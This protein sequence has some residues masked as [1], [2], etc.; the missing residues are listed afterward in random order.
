MREVPYLRVANVQRGFLDLAEMKTILAEEEEIDALRLREGDILFTEGGDRDKLGRGWVWN[1]EVAE[2]I[3]QNHIFR[4]RLYLP[5]LEPRFISYHG[6]HFGQKWFVR[7]GKQTTNLASINK[8]VLSRFPVPVAPAQEQRRIVA[9]IDEL[10]SDLD[11][12]VAALERVTANLKRYRAAVLKAAVEG[13][14]TAEW[15]K[16]N[17]PKET[18]QQLLTRIFAERRRKWEEEQLA[19]FAKAAKSPPAK[20]KE[21]Y[22]EPAGPDCTNLPTLPEGW[23]WASVDQAG[24]VQLGR[25]R[26]PKY[27]TG[28]HMRPYL[29][30]ANVFEDRIDTSDVMQMNFT[31]TEYETYRLGYGD[32]LLNEGQ[33]MELVGRPAIYR[34]EVPGACFTNTL[35]RFRASD[36]LDPEYALAVFLT[37]LKN[38][39][40]QK[41]ATI[42]VNIAHLGAGR[43][44]ELEFPLP[45]LAEQREIVS[46]VTRHDSIIKAVE[47]EVIAGIKR[48]SRLRQAILRRAFEGKLVPQDPRGEPAGVLLERIR[49]EKAETNG[50]AKPR[51]TK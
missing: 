24:D 15:R 27:H 6:N 29:R 13:R 26:S 20:W 46:E 22:K 7:A 41:I 17:R 45:P 25:Q 4:A 43:F 28:P 8:G 14:L 38:G 40:F 42:T 51:K 9:K 3:H 30:V 34:N 48:A 37:Y 19:A 49:A 47:N 39:R 31:P 16:K 5:D 33:S 18:G 12:G 36:G 11:A 32:V 1:G 21:K 50:K 2:C 44:A 10:F 35:V 23:C